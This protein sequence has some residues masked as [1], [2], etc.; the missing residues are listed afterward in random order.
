MLAAL[1]LPHSM[2]T[3][4]AGTGT[5][6]TSVR[7]GRRLMREVL[8]TMTPPGRTASSNLSREGRFKAMRPWGDLLM[9]DPMG[10]PDSTTVQL[11]VPPRISGP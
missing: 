10:R 4:L 2:A 11:Q 3:S 9:G 1:G 8:T 5:T 7:C 6:V